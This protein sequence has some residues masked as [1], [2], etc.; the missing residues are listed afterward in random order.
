MALSCFSQPKVLGKSMKNRKKTVLITGAGQ[1]IGQAM[2]SGMIP[3]SRE[4]FRFE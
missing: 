4:M 3:I 2:A 1:G